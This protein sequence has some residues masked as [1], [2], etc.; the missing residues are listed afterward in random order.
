MEL[1]IGSEFGDDS[2]GLMMVTLVPE[3]VLPWSA[4]AVRCKARSDPRTADYTRIR[5]SILF[6]HYHIDDRVDARCKVQQQVARHV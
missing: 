3:V 1:T 6:V 5:L 2:E 4:A